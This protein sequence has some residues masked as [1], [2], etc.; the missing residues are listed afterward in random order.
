MN[1]FIKEQNNDYIKRLSPLPMWW[2]DFVDK[3]K[4][5]LIKQGVMINGHWN[6]PKIVQQN[7]LQRFDKHLTN[8]KY[9]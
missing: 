7:L 3:D 9:I 2:H 4:S 8:E 5:H 1:W 6:P